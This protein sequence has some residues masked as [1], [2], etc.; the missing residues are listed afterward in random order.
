MALITH[1]IPR[2]AT[3]LCCGADSKGFMVVMGVVTAQW[4]PLSRIPLDSGFRRR[5]D[6]GGGKV[7]GNDEWR[8]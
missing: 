1:E 5:V 2:D 8:G 4:L 7:R 3:A 6:V